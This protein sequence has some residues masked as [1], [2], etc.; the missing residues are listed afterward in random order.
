MLSEIQQEKARR[1]FRIYDADD[2]GIIELED[3]LRWVNDIARRRG[4]DEDAPD[5][6]RLRSNAVSRW[7]TLQKYADD[8]TNERVTLAEYLYWTQR[9]L[10][11]AEESGDF[12]A[13][14]QWATDLFHFFDRENDGRVS[15]EEYRA[16]VEEYG[17]DAGSAE[18]NFRRLDADGDGYITRDE[19][20]Q[21]LIDFWV[22]EDPDA[23]ATYALGS[24]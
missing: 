21:L 9:R 13:Y 19:M 11:E 20:T 1:V 22:S 8:D 4:W 16:A 24:L 12:D 23:P 2:D 3:Y 10:E 15:L 5:Y 17:T 18:E 7:I 6:R 14:E